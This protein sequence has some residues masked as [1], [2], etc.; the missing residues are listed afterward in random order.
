MVASDVAARGLDLPQ[1]SHVFNYD[2]PIHADD[3]IHRIGRTG[4]AGRSGHAFMLAAP[5]DHKFLAA[6]ERLTGIPLVREEMPGLEG[7]K[8]SEAE[9][10]SGGRDRDR[11]RRGGRG[12]DRHRDR[13]PHDKP[14]HEHT[15][16][17][18]AEQAPALAET[19]PA[20][21]Q[22]PVEHKHREHKPRHA[23]KPKPEHQ[24][25]PQQERQPRAQQERQAKA[26][27]EHQP[28]AQ[29]H[30]KPKGEPRKQHADAKGGGDNKVGMGE[31]T[32]AFLLKPVPPH[33]LRKK[34]ETEA[35]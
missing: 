3:Y 9:N 32:P 15:S 10:R 14:R 12:G 29:A 17:A 27:H 13:R 31:H 2:V 25:K 8:S 7:I 18:A 23:D 1:V 26:P 19:T 28:K 4:R 22:A 16:P 33:L 20:P 5:S 30:Q 21:T 24:H 34:K 35:A 11:D 6:I